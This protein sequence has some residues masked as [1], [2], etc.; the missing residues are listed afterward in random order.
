MEVNV[1]V[2]HEHPRC[3]ERIRLYIERNE[4]CTGLHKLPFVP[5]KEDLTVCELCSR[6]IDPFLSGLFDNPN[7]GIYLRWTNESTL[8]VKQLSNNTRPDLTITETAGLKWAR[9]IG[10]REPKPAAGGSDHYLVCQD[11][12]KVV[13]FCKNPLDE[14]LMEGI[15]GI[16]IVGRTIWFYVVVLLAIATYAMYLLAETKAPDSIQGFPGLVAELPSVLKILHI[17]DTV[18]VHSIT[19]NVIASR[20]A[21]TLSSRACQQIKS[22]SKSRKRACHLYCI[23]N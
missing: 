10:Y 3:V 15:L 4:D 7:Q 1:E 2:I 5:L 22:E 9:S 23:H 17:C 11:L 19:P 8:E 14:H 12:I 18:C 13:L 6:F 20:R 16:H 21:P